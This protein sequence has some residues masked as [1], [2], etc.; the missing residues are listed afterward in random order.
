MTEQPPPAGR[1]TPAQERA[2]REEGLPPKTTHDAEQDVAAGEAPDTPTFGDRPE[3]VA[4]IDEQ[5]VRDGR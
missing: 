1:P 3:P 5:T 4:P 2:T